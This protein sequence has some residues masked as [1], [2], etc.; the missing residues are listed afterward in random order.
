[1]FVLSEGTRRE[2]R[3]GTERFCA[4]CLSVRCL[5]SERGLDSRQVM[6]TMPYG[7]VLEDKL[8]S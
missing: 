1:M 3:G 5:R 2:H 8:A 6:I 7:V 4:T